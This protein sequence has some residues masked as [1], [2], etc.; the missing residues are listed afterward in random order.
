MRGRAAADPRACSCGARGRQPSL[1]RSPGAWSVDVEYGLAADA[2][3]QQGVDRGLGLAPGA[4][5]F[6]LAIEPSAGGQRTQAAQIT[7]RAAMAGEFVRQVQRA[8][9][10]AAG[11]V[12]TPGP[13]ADHVLL[14]LRRDI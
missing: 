6:N 11:T 10:R 12:E 4:L 13:E 2:A 14:V 1:S 7:G 9:P 8:D 3:V 5:E